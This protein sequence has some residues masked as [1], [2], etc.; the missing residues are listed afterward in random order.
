[1]SIISASAV[2]ASAH[3]SCTYDG[4]PTAR[5]ERMNVILI[6]LD[7]LRADSL[8]V[9]GNAG[10]NSPSIDALARKSTVYLDTLASS[11]WTLPSHASMFTGLYPSNHAAHCGYVEF[12][13]DTRTIAQLLKASGFET[14]SFN[15]G[16]NVGQTS[17]SHA[18][19]RSTS[20]SSSHS[21]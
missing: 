19:S 18:G 3:A 20:R 7:T 4:K 9:Y 12:T 14:I 10:D 2:L 15:G 11:P 21:V 6:S 17:V 5:N 16:G 1:M 13:R 8:G